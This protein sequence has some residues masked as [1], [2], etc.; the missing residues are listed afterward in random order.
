M[1]AD[2]SYVSHQ[3]FA[4]RLYDQVA[5]LLQATR[6]ARAPRLPGELR[7]LSDHLLNDIGMD[8]RD[9]PSEPSFLT[10]PDILHSPH[11]MKAFLAGTR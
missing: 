7:R 3:P 8:R 2:T 4:E 9:L 11:M 10:P 1:F 5:R 6:P